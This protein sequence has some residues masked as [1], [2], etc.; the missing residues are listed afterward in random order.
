MAD[1]A[2]PPKLELPT[3]IKELPVIEDEKNLDLDPTQDQV[4]PP[5]SD[6]NGDANANANANENEGA[7]A[8]KTP[9]QPP[10]AAIDNNTSSEQNVPIDFVTMGMFII[11]EQTSV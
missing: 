5:D 3:D 8:D 6:T 7:D 10:L 4:Q 9:E 11:G 2:E 1:L